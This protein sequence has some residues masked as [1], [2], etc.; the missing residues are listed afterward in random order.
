[1]QLNG[2]YIKKLVDGDCGSTDYIEW[3]VRAD[4]GN[5]KNDLKELQYKYYLNEET[6]KLEEITPKHTHLVG[7][8]IKL[9]SA[10]TCKLK[11]KGHVCSK[12]FGKLAYSDP[13][14]SNIG[15]YTVTTLTRIIT[16]SL[17][18]N[19]HLVT[20]ATSVGITLDLIANKF[21][22]IKNKDTLAFRSNALKSKSKYYIVIEQNQ[23]YGLKDLNANTN[24]KKLMPNRVSRIKEFMLKVVTHTNEVLYYPISIG[25]KKKYGNFTYEFLAHIAK[26]GYEVD[27]MDRY[28]I[29]I[30]E[31]ITSA[32]HIIKMPQAEYNFLELAKAIKAEF[33]SLET[34]S[35]V[36][37][38]ESPESL[39]Q[40]I[41]DMVM[42]KLSINIAILET[43]I[44][45]FMVYDFKD[46]NFDLGRNSADPQLASLRELMP[47]RSL[48]AALAW[49]DYNSARYNPNLFYKES[50]IDHPL[51][52]MIK[53]N[54]TIK[55][56]Y[57]DNNA[58]VKKLKGK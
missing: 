16:Q 19:K 24:I 29:P 42:S 31:D 18:S 21:F 48:G 23:G 15:M 40:K 52:V 39:L 5:G 53:P 35:G 28:I 30:T 56:L 2:M 11:N 46:D 55:Y 43:I 34:I 54:E 27:D 32:T 20:S 25:D 44:A 37:S 7:K 10:I 4:N 26:V 57:G 22:M 51:D 38:I 33:K 17:L 3:L 12:C 49:E 41:F 58:I 14:P 1:M 50:V 47:N 8:K 45:S 6:G 13:Q 36:G 9:R